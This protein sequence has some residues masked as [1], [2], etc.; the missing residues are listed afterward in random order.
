MKRNLFIVIIFAVAFAGIVWFGFSNTYNENQNTQA[1]T[2]SETVSPN[3]DLEPQT[4]DEGS[5]TVSVAPRKSAGAGTWEFE[6]TL[7]THSI[8]LSEDLITATV[9]IADKKEYQPIAWNGD[10]PGGH[11]R[12]GILQF[13]PIS[14]SPQSVAL[15]IS[16]VGGVEERNFIWQLK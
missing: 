16:N 6:I 12:N 8:E 1:P 14:P 15:K 5:V 2:L 9:L 10:P 3:S 7:N 13:S 4:N 11:H